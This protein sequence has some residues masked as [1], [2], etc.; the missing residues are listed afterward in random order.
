MKFMRMKIEDF[1]EIA[2][3][4]SKKKHKQNAEKTF[5]VSIFARA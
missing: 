3:K 2:G 4:V 5:P 1:K